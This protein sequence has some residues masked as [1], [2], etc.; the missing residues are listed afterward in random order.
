MKDDD[1]KGGEGN[2]LI[3]GGPGTD[4]LRGGSGDDIFLEIG[5]GVSDDV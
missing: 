2:D 4:D 5:K 3:M 1:L